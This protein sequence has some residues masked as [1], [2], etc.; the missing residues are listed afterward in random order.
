MLRDGTPPHTSHYRF[1]LPQTRKVLGMKT[2]SM[3]IDSKFASS[4]AKDEAGEILMGD[5]VLKQ[6]L[7]RM[8]MIS[9]MSEGDLPNSLS[10]PGAEV[11][12]LGRKVIGWEGGPPG[13]M[14]VQKK[15][16]KK[17]KDKSGGEKEKR[18]VEKQRHKDWEAD[19][20][21][22]MVTTYG[23]KYS[24]EEMASFGPMERKKY[25]EGFAELQGK[26][27]DIRG[28]RKEAEPAL[29]DWKEPW[30]R[31]ELVEGGGEEEEEEEA[32]DKGGET[33]EG[34]EGEGK[35]GAQAAEEE[36]K[37][38]PETIATAAT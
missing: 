16:P 11:K 25:K 8:D 2:T 37:I 30:K 9:I 4:S 32:G 5:E 20:D 24:A 26:I 29:K 28:K 10:H 12:T 27:K 31:V 13:L 19:V 3:S 1:A 15:P 33:G 35:E 23:R 7:A 21:E 6:V 36:K 17:K 18:R 22:A 14:G 38:E 34:T